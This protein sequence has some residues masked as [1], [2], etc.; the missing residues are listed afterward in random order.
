[1]KTRADAAAPA[2]TSAIVAATSEAQP[3]P[4]PADEPVLAAARRFTQPLL[5]TRALDTGEDAWQHAEGVAGILKSLGAAEP[6]QAAAYLVYAGDFLQDPEDIIGR[7]FGASYA[8]LV[9]LTRKL[10]Q[11]QRMTLAPDG[12]GQITLTDTADVSRVTMIVSALAPWTVGAL[13]ETRG[14]TTAFS[15]AAVAFVLAGVLWIWIPE[16]RGRALE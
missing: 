4:L 14:F 2:E 12:S 16:T 8:G 7:V 15:T 10:V 1:M 3:T 11:V 9:G 13:A 6:L 5:A